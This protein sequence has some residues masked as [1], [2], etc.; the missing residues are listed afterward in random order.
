MELGKVESTIKEY[1][2]ALDRNAGEDHSTLS[3][4]YRE[5]RATVLEIRKSLAAI[6]R[7]RENEK[8]IFDESSIEDMNDELILLHNL[9]ADLPTYL[10]AKMKSFAMNVRL[11]YRTWIGLTWATT[12]SAIPLLFLTGLCLYTWI[13]CPLRTIL[14]GSREIAA[15]NFERRIEL[16]SVDEMGEVADAMNQ[17]TSRFEEIR[18]DLDKKVQATH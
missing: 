11:K 18:D 17:M 5:E 13:F 14:R 15:G 4:T 10:Q 8:W 6:Q 3:D 1:C 16:K 7:I 12:L 9:A 2:E